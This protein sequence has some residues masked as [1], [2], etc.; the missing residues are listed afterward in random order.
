[1]PDPTNYVHNV[2][3]IGASASANT[4]TFKTLDKCGIR[5]RENFIDQSPTRPHS[6]QSDKQVKDF[7]VPKG[8]AHARYK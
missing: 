6:F 2:T 8:H 7:R 1:M 4:K 5:I 3:L